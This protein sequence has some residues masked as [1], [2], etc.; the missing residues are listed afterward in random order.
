MR[1]FLQWGVALTVS[2]SSFTMADSTRQISD[3]PQIHS[4]NE[5]QFCRCP[6]EGVRV[7]NS[8]CGM[9]HVEY[10][11]AHVAPW[12]SVRQIAEWMD[13]RCAQPDLTASEQLQACAHFDPRIELLYNHPVNWV[14]AAPRVSQYLYNGRWN[15]TSTVR[16][17]GIPD[18]IFGQC[19]MAVSSD[20]VLELLPGVRGDF[21]RAALFLFDRYSIVLPAEIE[22]DL[23]ELGRKDP[24]TL[25]ESKREMFRQSQHREYNLY[26]VNNENVDQARNKAH[27]LGIM[28]EYREEVLPR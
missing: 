26:V 22:R 8:A 13:L 12:L 7:D 5:T 25:A 2:L 20:G 11:R 10:N 3:V 4:V 23:I 18:E 14:V 9:P 6:I 15:W 27:L 1:D 28:N 17:P 16:T 24:V 19:P 21:A